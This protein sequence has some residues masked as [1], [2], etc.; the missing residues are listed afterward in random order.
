MAVTLQPKPHNMHSRIATLM[1]ADMVGY[2]LLMDRDSARAIGAVRELREKHLEPTV[3][4]HGGEILKRMGDGWIFA[5]GSADDQARCALEVQSALAGHELIKLRIGA[6]VGEILEDEHDFY[7]AGVNLAQRLQTESPPGGIMISQDLHT[8]LAEKLKQHF[9]DAGSFQLKNIA[10]PVNGFQ[11]RPSVCIE[12]GG[13][14]RRITGDVPTVA[15]EP[16]EYSPDETEPRAVAADLR[17]QES[18]R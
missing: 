12:T 18:G 11:W 8:R 16:F 15:V 10:Q 14:M 2:S 3:L 9:R 6:H 5:F 1:V 17:D 13:E 4:K 7:G